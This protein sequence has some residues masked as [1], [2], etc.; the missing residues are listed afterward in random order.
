MVGALRSTNAQ[1]NMRGSENTTKVIP[2]STP[3]ISLYGVICHKANF[4]LYDGI[5]S[6]PV[7]TLDAVKNTFVG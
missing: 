7:Q 6:E 1:G 4:A 3:S 2:V 5:C